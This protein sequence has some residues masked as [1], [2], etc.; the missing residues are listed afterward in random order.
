MSNRINKPIN[1]WTDEQLVGWARG[2]I[3]AGQATTEKQLANALG[4]KHDLEVGEDLDAFKA[5]AVAKADGGEAALQEAPSV[6]ATPEAEQ[7]PVA[8]KPPEP[9]QEETQP[10]PAPTNTPV[11]GQTASVQQVDE[12]PFA[13]GQKSTSLMIVEDNLATYVDKMKP[14]AA[15]QGNE[16][17]TAQVLLYRTVQTILR[18]KGSDFNF[19]FGELLKTVHKH[20]NSVFNERYV[21]RYMDRLSLTSSERRN[22]ERFINML[23]TVCDPATR[24]HTLKQVDI[25]ATMEGFKDPD[26]H[27]RV[28]A[29]FQV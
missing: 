10:E 4:K 12:S 13:G 14:G 5:E 18:Q 22:F 2:E 15:H 29:F 28:V 8:E 25:N 9:V 21:F 24:S 7:A 17:P 6:E 27:Q 20:R 26:A 16:G 3:V 11:R 23:L 1:Q 19:L